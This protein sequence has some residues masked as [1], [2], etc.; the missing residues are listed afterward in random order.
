M[1]DSDDLPTSWRVALS[2][3]LSTAIA[4][5]VRRIEAAQAITRLDAETQAAAA[6]LGVPP[7]ATADE[8]RATLRRKLAET[9][10]HPDQGGDAEITRALI[11][12]RTLLLDR[13]RRDPK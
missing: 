9:R 1:I 3:L 2:D 11:E 8:I 4:A 13:S 12:A 5:F 6:L 10:C 7:D